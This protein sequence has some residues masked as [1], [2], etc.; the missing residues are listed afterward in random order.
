LSI[1]S[2]GTRASAAGSIAAVVHQ[3][4]TSSRPSRA[5]AQ[6]LAPPHKGQTVFGSA[7]KA[8]IRRV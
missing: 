3:H 7:C 5:G 8:V 1:R 6:A 4:G 2:G